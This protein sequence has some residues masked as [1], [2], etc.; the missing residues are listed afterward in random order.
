MQ[1]IMFLE[2]MFL[3]VVVGNKTQ[4]R[5]IIFPK[6][7]YTFWPQPDFLGMEKDPDAVNKTNKDG[8]IICKKDGEEKLFKLKGTYGLFEGDQFELDNSYVKPR[9][10]PDE[11]V[12]LK[13]PYFIWEPEHCESMSK[14]FCYKY[15]LDKE[16]EGFRKYELEMGYEHYYWHNKMF[17]P[18]SYARYFIKI[19]DVTAQRLND[20]TEAE[21]R[22]EG[23]RNIADSSM[24]WIT[25]HGFDSWPSNPWVWKYEFELYK[26]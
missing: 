25:L 9:Y 5:R 12:Y 1:G 22:A 13:E 16:I 19:K 2:P 24:T 4:T 3:A 7:D 18:E 14:R 20:I 8:E 23:F 11:I 6:T 10:Q 26:K 21:A 17:M 15:G